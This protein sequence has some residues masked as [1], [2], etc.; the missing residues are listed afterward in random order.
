MRV[1]EVIKGEIEDTHLFILFCDQFIMCVSNVSDV[2]ISAVVCILDY[3][4]W[5]GGGGAGEGDEAATVAFSLTSAMKYC[6]CQRVGL[7]VKASASRAEDLGCDSCLLLRDFSGSSHTSDL[8]K[9]KVGTPVATLPGAW[10][11]R[12][13]AGTGWPGV[14]MLWL[15]EVCNFCL[16]VAARKLVWA[17]W[18]TLIIMLLGCYC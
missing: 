2:W 4:G 3:Q 5:W 10:R 15:S 8:N 6:L 13:S 17:D 14:S 11:Y 1:P 16:N 12:V 18:D 7:V 9:L